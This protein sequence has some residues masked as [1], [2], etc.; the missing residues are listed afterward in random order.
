MSELSV[1][2]WSGTLAQIEEGLC[3]VS[4]KTPSNTLENLVLIYFKQASASAFVLKSPI[5]IKVWVWPTKGAPIKGVYK[6]SPRAPLPFDSGIK[7]LGNYISVYTN[8]NM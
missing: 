3:W 5:E 8:H 6:I 1:K 2:S 4:F 7:T